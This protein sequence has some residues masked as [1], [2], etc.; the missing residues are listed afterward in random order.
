MISVCKRVRNAIIAN[1]QDA[2]LDFTLTERIQASAMLYFVAEV[3]RSIR[4]APREVYIRCKLPDRRTSQGVIVGQVLD[5]IGFLDRIGQPPPMEHGGEEFDATVKNWRYATGTRIDESPGDVLDK[6][7]GRIAP[8]L[9][10]KMH[11]GLSEAI[12]NSLHHAY[13]ADRRDGCRHFAERRWWMF[14]REQEGILEVLVCDLGIGIPRSL[15]I[16]WDKKFLAKIASVFTADGADVAAV[17]SALV[18]GESSTKDENR[19]RGLPQVWDATLNAAEG[20]VGI[21][22]DRAYLGHV[23]GAPKQSEFEDRLL[24]TIVTWRVPVSEPN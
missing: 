4:M 21:F 5:Q 22:S 6:Y 1:G 20:A 15:P 23:K 14:T 2:V 9:M 11:I 7:E 13:L 8:A 12:I 16:S 3:D 10:T 18:L 19:G 24:G 17:K